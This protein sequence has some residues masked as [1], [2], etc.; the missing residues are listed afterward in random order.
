MKRQVKATMVDPTN[1]FRTEEVVD[2]LRFSAYRCFPMSGLP[3][4]I[5]LV[6]RIAEH[7]TK[8]ESPI[9]LYKIGPFLDFLLDCS[10]ELAKRVSAIIDDDAGISEYHGIPCLS[11]FDTLANQPGVVFICE[12]ETERRWQLERKV[13]STMSVLSPD[14]A[15]L[16]GALVPGRAWI[17]D[18]L[19]IYPF[20]LPD[21]EFHHGLDVLLLDLPSRAGLQFPVGVAYIHKALKRSSVIFQTSD[22]GTIMY[23]RFQI[24]RLYDL[25]HEPVLR[26]GIAMSAD[27]WGYNERVWV[28]PRYWPFLIDYFSEEI[29]E[30]VDK[31]KVAKPKIL[32]MSIHQRNEWITREITRRIKKVLPDTVILVG[33]HSCYSAEMGKGAFPEYD[34]MVI[35]EADLLIG[36]LVEALARGE[37]PVNLPGILSKYDD[38]DRQFLPGAVPHNLDM[39]GE[40]NF[41]VFDNIN[42]M[43]RDWRGF[44]STALPLTR[45]CVWARCSFCAERFAFRSRTPKL[46]VD[47]IEKLIASGRS[48]DF[49]ASDSDFGGRPEII[50]EVCEEIV[51]RG[52]KIDF[53]GQIRVNKKF[54]LEFLKLMRAAGVTG[55][56]FGA[57]AFTLN[58][59]RRQRKGYTL[60][61]LIQNYEDCL[62]AGITPST[63]IVVGVP[64]ET[65]Q[66]IDD[67][68]A[69]ITKNKHIFLTINNINCCELMSNSVYWHEPEKHNI[70]FYGNKDEIYKKYYFG[71]PQGLWYSMDPYMD[72]AVRFEHTRR[73][74]VGLHTA[75]IPLGPEVLS[76]YNAMLAGVGHVEYRVMSIDSALALDRTDPFTMPSADSYLPVRTYDDRLI[77]WSDDGSCMAFSYNKDV[78]DSM[79]HIGRPFWWKGSLQLPQLAEGKS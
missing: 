24:H 14:M 74:V 8:I 9:F 68:V 1:N 10:L 53:S 38:P 34:Y 48:R 66:D 30:I 78:H 58:T 29:I 44:S 42:E 13:P 3:D 25:G 12:R 67:T 26:N 4:E 75:G 39:I 56:N 35:G 77:I 15:K 22:C 61:T 59:I 28:D 6:E 17:A 79:H 73:L 76:N 23:H 69:F 32:A 2:V 71:V 45:G 37:H 72:K 18:E 19:N 60:Q 11:S 5:Q 54:D 50:R 51:R 31:L 64:G 16:F 33:G 49:Q 46:Y 65:D 40:L 70:F 52:L 27:A 62:R 43:Y 21:I 63:N 7:I 47:E 20:T 55:L 36:S 41:E 57:D